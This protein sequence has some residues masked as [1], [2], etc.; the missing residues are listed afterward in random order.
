[1]DGHKSESQ[2]LEAMERY[3]LDTLTP[4][5]TCYMM[6]D[7]V[8]SL[9]L[10]ILTHLIPITTLHPFH[11]GGTKAQGGS[12]TSP[13]K[14]VGRWWRSL[15]AKSG[16]PLLHYSIPILYQYPLDRPRRAR[17]RSPCF[18]AQAKG[19]NSRFGELE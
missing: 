17:P 3:S 6:D 8:P 10:Q 14:R 1:M 4:C 9:L 5:S 15:A 13:D 2:Q 11:I 18:I 7:L 16:S 12:I 19:V